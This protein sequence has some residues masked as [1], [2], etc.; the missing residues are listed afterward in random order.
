MSKTVYIVTMKARAG[1]YSYFIGAYSSLEK[2]TDA[3][4]TEIK[5]R[6]KAFNG[7]F[8]AEIM[9]VVLNSEKIVSC[10]MIEWEGGNEQ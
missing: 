5:R 6:L 2:A 7:N 4:K 10:K 8:D 1:H 9:G 3:A